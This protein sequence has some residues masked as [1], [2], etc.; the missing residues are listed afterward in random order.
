MSKK[1]KL[2]ALICIL[3]AAAVFSA[4]AFAAVSNR[5]GYERIKAALFNLSGAVFTET[6]ATYAISISLARAGGQASVA[7]IVEWT[8]TQVDGDRSLTKSGGHSPGEIAADRVKRI[9]YEEPDVVVSIYDGHYTERQNYGNSNSFSSAS[10][11][12]T[13]IADNVSPVQ[14]RFFEAL[15]DALVGDTKNQF[16]TDGDTVSLSL[17]DQQIPELAQ[18]ALSVIAEEANGGFGGEE[19]GYSSGSGDWDF[20]I[21]RDAKFAWVNFSAALDDRLGFASAHASFAISSTVGGEER[22]YEARFDYDV[23]DVGTTVVEK[24]S[25]EDYESSDGPTAPAYGGNDG[26]IIYGDEPESFFYGDEPAYGGDGPADYFYGIEP[27]APG[28]YGDGYGFGYGY[29]DGYEY[30]AAPAF[31]GAPELGGASARGGEAEGFFFGGEPDARGGYG[32][33]AGRAAS[34]IGPDSEFL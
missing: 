6:N 12:W 25:P 17:S 26:V 9:T 22:T 1:K 28:G 29:G 23:T 34:A 21:G 33:G 5:S 14:L 2:T 11:L 31:G 7:P 13:S 24:P 20:A 4:S 18:L 27:D 16:V 19:G 3:A 32:Y 30:Y 15:T 8:T 10:L